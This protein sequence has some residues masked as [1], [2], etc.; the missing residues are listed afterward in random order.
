MMSA[1][2][3]TPPATAMARLDVA[4]NWIDTMLF[5]ATNIVAPADD[6]YRSLSDEQKPRLDN[7]KL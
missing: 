4:L 7:L 2:P 6:F 3:Q 5:A 1:C